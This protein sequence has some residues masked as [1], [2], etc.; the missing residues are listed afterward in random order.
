MVELVKTINEPKIRTNSR[1][2]ARLFI[3][4]KYKDEYRELCDAY[5]ENRGVFGIRGR[6]TDAT[7]VVDERTGQ[8]YEPTPYKEFTE[9]E[10]KRRAKVRA[11][12]STYA[13]TFLVHKYRKEWLELCEAYCKNRGIRYYKSEFRGS[14]VDEREL[15]GQ[16]A[17]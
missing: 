7:D 2:Y 14:L 5:S 4:N 3:A 11:D 16:H 15:L 13:R 1:E 10:K 9:K 17:E 8:I 12:A 6:G